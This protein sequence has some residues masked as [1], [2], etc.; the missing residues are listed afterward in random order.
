MDIGGGQVQIDDITIVTDA[1]GAIEVADGSIGGDKLDPATINDFFLTF[2]E[3]KNYALLTEGAG[4]TDLDSHNGYRLVLKDCE[5]N[6]ATRFFINEVNNN[7]YKFIKTNG[8][9]V[10]QSTFNLM[11]ATRIS[12]YIDIYASQ[13]SDHNLVFSNLIADYSSGIISDLVKGDMVEDIDNKIES[14]T[15]GADGYKLKGDLTL[16]GIKGFER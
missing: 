9:V 2:L 13:T 11:S 1:N 10:T 12:G 16:Y 15:F 14:L 7:V 8:S 3:T 4:F 6:G 5:V